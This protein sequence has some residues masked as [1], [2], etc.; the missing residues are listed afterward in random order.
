MIFL[1]AVFLWTNIAGAQVIIT[2]NDFANTGDKMVLAVDT[3]GLADPVDFRDV[4]QKPWDF[5]ARKSNVSDTIQFIEAH[6]TKYASS[7]P[8]ANIATT[9]YGLGLAY[10]E[11]TRDAA[12][13]HG[14]VL[15][16]RLADSILNTRNSAFRLLPGIIQSGIVI[17]LP[18]PVKLMEFPSRI[19]D[20]FASKDSFEYAGTPEEFGI[21]MDTL[22]TEPDSVK[23]KVIL[24]IESE[25]IDHG[26]ITTPAGNYPCLLEDRKTI[27]FGG[28][29]AYIPYIG[30]V[31]TPG[32]SKSD[33]T[34][35]YNWWAKE[36]GLPV[37]SV[38]E[39]QNTVTNITY[40]KEAS[41]E[42][43]GIDTDV[44]V[45]PNPTQEKLY[46]KSSEHKVIQFSLYDSSGKIIRELSINRRNY[47]I[48]LRGLAAG[49]YIYNLTLDNDSTKSGKISIQ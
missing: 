22:D 23:L 15:G 5:S 13:W 24:K 19:G 42:N 20:T 39:I 34:H 43:S 18:Q 35:T 49:E 9:N 48:S 30:W 47:F 17:D 46:I 31:A 8:Q 27:L 28:I 40:L 3:V 26:E 33:T 4:T 36:K 16:A 14:V 44:L 2:Y 37:L 25:F 21:N 6:K 38:S 41:R 29:Y 10:L 12:K 45:Y 32:Y 7:F 1:C 11:K